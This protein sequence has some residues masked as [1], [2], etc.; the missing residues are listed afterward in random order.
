[1]ILSRD[2]PDETPSTNVV[3]SIAE[4]TEAWSVEQYFSGLAAGRSME[5]W[6]AIFAI[7]EVRVDECAWPL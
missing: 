2:F 7:R 4:H 6:K 5:M 1:M 3:G